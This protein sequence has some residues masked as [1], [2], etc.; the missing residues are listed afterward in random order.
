MPLIRQRQFQY[1]RYADSRR[2]AVVEGAVLP[3]DDFQVY[4]LR[5]A[6]ADD[7]LLAKISTRRGKASSANESHRPVTTS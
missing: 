4:K 7:E 3:G 1:R 2:L 6:G 5:K